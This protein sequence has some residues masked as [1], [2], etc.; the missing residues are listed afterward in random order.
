MA[1]R[2]D[3]YSRL[4]TALKVVL[5]IT[6][7]ALLSTLFFFS[8]QIDPTQSLPYKELD[9]ESIAREQR[10]S[11]PSSSG[12]TNDGSAFKM[13]AD[14]A[15]PDASDDTITRFENLNIELVDPDTDVRTFL[16][17]PTGSSNSATGET[18]LSGG[19]EIR[20]TDGMLIQAET[21]RMFLDNDEIISDGPVTA[22]GSFGDLEA[23][24]MRIARAG[25]GQDHLA[26]FN[27]GV[28]LIYERESD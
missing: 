15:L 1:S 12:V 2:A 14:R 19:T 20:S 18:V 9:V 22:T 3:G 7:V 21:L 28:N 4:V 23:G 27:N 13:T 11:K 17:A 10:L 8:G 16:S 25:P 6:A 26:V 5:P 24:S